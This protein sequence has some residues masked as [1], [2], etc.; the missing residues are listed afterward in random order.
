MYTWRKLTKEQGE[1]I[2]ASRQKNQR[3]WHRPPHFDSDGLQSF[4]LSAACYEH[5]PIIGSS[6]QRIEEFESQLIGTLSTG[7]NLLHAWCVLPN[8]WHAL[9]QTEGLKAVTKSIGQ[10]H[11]RVSFSWNGEDGSRGRKCWHGCSDRRIRSSRHFYVAQNYIHHN[12]VKHGLIETSE[13]WP[14][15]SAADYMEKIGREN[16]TK[17]WDEYPVL[18][19]GNGWDD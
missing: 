1:Q 13:E 6:L 5:V 7:D 19:M 9:I 16:V 15:S 14:F 17:Q 2:L 18:D 11:G 8:H 12:P 3:P 10:L 4:H